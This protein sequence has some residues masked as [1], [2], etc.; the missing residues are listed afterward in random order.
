MGISEPYRSKILR[1]D[2]CLD[3]LYNIQCIKSKSKYKRVEK[4]ELAGMDDEA[5]AARN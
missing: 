5:N 2:L 1:L 4:V 3:M